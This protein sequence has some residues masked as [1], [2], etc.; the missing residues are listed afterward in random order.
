MKKIIIYDFD[1]T[2]TPYSLP[3][4]EILEK[5]GMKDGAYNPKFLELSQKRAKD[6]NIDLYKAIYDTYFMII[7]NAG[8]KL[9]DENFSLGYNNTEYN[10]GVIEFLNMLYQNNISNYLLSS[11]LKVFL[12]KISISSYFK[13]IYATIFTYNQDYEANGL[14]FLMSDKNKVIAIKEILYKN[15]IDNE[16]C[17]NVIYIGD[18]FTDYYAMKYIKEHGGTSIFVYQNLDSKDMQSI[19]EENVVDF[20]TKADFSQNSELYNYVK[21][22]CKIK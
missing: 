20:Y 12:E 4:F 2:L 18:G 9:T 21:R 15:N 17:S 19:K 6:E 5:S 16:D 22:L 14:E 1:G 11:G 7:K 13:E 3:K 8:L 10:N